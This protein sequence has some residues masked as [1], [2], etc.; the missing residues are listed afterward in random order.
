[1]N[2]NKQYTRSQ[3]AE[4]VGEDKADAVLAR[5]NAASV[6]LT[7]PQE[8]DA[9]IEKAN[10]VGKQVDR[11]ALHTRRKDYSGADRPLSEAEA[12][13]MIKAYAAGDEPTDPDE[14]E[15]QASMSRQ[16]G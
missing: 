3:V 9:L 8:Q 6:G 15:K 10:R 13:T 4:I 16:A 7:S 14:L 5:L 12:R 2:R 1:M 11:A